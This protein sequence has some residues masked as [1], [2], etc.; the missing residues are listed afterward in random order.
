MFTKP[1]YLRKKVAVKITTIYYKNVKFS[2]IVRWYVGPLSRVWLRRVPATYF[3]AIDW[4]HQS[5]MEL[6]PPLIDSY[7]NQACLCLLV[8]ICKIFGKPVMAR[9]NT[10]VADLTDQ[11]RIF[12]YLKFQQYSK[13]QENVNSSGQIWSYP[14]IN[15]LRKGPL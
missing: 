3:R 9:G 14:K 15:P 1:L 6:F 4:L 13:F 7:R 10:R 2:H 11:I 5:L 8:F 12:P